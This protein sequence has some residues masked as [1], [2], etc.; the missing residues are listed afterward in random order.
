MIRIHFKVIFIHSDTV[1][2]SIECVVIFPCF[3]IDVQRPQE[4]EVTIRSSGIIQQRQSDAPYADWAVLLKGAGD[5]FFLHSVGFLDFDC[6]L[7]AT[8]R[9]HSYR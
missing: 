3:R 2:I 7:P 8:P 4:S 9:S 5:E 1:F 6:N